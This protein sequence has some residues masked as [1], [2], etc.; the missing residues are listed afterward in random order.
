[1]EVVVTKV[2]VMFLWAAV[3]MA[4]GLLPVPV[5]RAL[6]NSRRGRKL[7]DKVVGAV[8]CIGGGVLLATVFIHMLPEVQVRKK[9]KVCSRRTYTGSK[10]ISRQIV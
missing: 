1:M 10:L 7:V 9:K 2:L 5:Y 6:A 8:L 4:S 3:K